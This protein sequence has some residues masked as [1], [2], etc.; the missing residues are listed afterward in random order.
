MRQ[1]ISLGQLLGGLLARAAASQGGRERDGI[2]PE[3]KDLFGLGGAEEGKEFDGKASSRQIELP[4]PKAAVDIEELLPNIGRSINFLETL[5]GVCGLHA[6]QISDALPDEQP[7]TLEELVDGCD[8]E[9]LLAAF[10]AAL[11]AVNLVL[12]QSVG[13]EELFEEGIANIQKVIS[14]LGAFENYNSDGEVESKKFVL[15]VTGTRADIREFEARYGEACQNLELDGI[16][17]CAQQYGHRL[18]VALGCGALEAS[19]DHQHI[20]AHLPNV[21]VSAALAKAGVP[22]DD[23][24]MAADESKEASEEPASSAT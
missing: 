4:T 5:A 17:A 1:N 13:S 8:V 14:D 21:D 16:I 11:A 19:A 7:E 20:H 3:L 9:G 12:A 10:Q 24:E 6:A 15:T 22:Q 18:S 2:P 23:V